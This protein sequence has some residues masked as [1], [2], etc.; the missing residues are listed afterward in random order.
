MNLALKM[1]LVILAALFGCSQT[2]KSDPGIPVSNQMPVDT[3]DKEIYDFMKEL[4]SEEHLSL[5]NGL[6]TVPQAN[7]NLLKPDEEYLNNFLIGSNKN[8]NSLEQSSGKF[9]NT[10]DQ[11][12]RCLSKEDINFM[13]NQKNAH[14]TFKWNNYRLGFNKENRNLWYI[15]SIPLFSKDKTRVLMMIRALCPG[16]CGTGSTVLFKKENGKWISETADL[17]YH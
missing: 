3:S 14:R 10:F 11:F 5:V 12:D 7:C 17:W 1:L 13:L 2:P 15:F 6:E 4:I 8:R 16:L 9:S